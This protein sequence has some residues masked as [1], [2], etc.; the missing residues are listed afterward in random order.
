MQRE[1]APWSQGHVALHS[2]ACCREIEES[3]FTSAV[4]GLDVD[5]VP[6]I[7]SWAASELHIDLT[8]DGYSLSSNRSE[9][10]QPPASRRPHSR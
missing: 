6:H 3:S 10:T 8:A 9:C 4:V 7:F 5:G 2:A 1:V